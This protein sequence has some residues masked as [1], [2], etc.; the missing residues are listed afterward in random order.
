[1]AWRREKVSELAIDLNNAGV[2]RYDRWILRNVTWQAPSGSCVGILG[3]NGGGKSTLARIIAGFL[4]PSQGVCRILGCEFGKTNIPD[5]RKRIRLIQ[6]AGPYDVDSDLTVL[7]AVL[8]GHF[9]SMALYETPSKEQKA[10]ASE[11]MARLGL[12]RLSEHS[13]YTLSSGE[14]TRM[15]IARALVSKPEIL[16]LDE[17]TAGLD[18]L[19][20][21][22]V[23]HGVQSLFDMVGHRITVV[24]ITHHV[25]ELPAATAEILLLANGEIVAKGKPSEVLRDETL[26]K[27]Y[28]C[29]VKVRH[30][31]KRWY[32]EV[33][34]EVKF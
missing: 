11:M 32:W 8:T 27:A 23:L 19:A 17:P 15:L 3:P 5:L 21:E 13:I 25:E 34:G 4:Y 26:S 9:N 20:R 33:N 29:S 1:M 18:L 22:Q 16:I 7:N 24:M 12:T 30:S 31:R 14:K 10:V 28:G 2:F 6:A